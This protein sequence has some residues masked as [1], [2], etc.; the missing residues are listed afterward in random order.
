MNSHK[1]KT[2]WHRLIINLHQPQPDYNNKN[3]NNNRI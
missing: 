1:S 3:N 2:N